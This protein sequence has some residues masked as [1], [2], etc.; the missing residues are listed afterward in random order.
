M[1]LGGLPCERISL[2]DQVDDDWEVLSLV[3]GWQQ[4]ADAEFFRSGTRGH[5][6]RDEDM[7]VECRGGRAL[8]KRA[9]AA[10][11]A[12]VQGHHDCH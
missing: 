1:T 8:F 5:T 10:A 7:N 3:E 4:D 12:D 9:A 11:A 2:V 6:R